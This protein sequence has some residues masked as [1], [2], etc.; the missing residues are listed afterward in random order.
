M[1][2]GERALQSM[3]VGDVID[4]S[5]EIYKRNFKQLTTLALIFYIPFI[6]I[7]SAVISYFSADVKNMT[8]GRGILN[9]DV[10][11]FTYMFMAYYLILLG[12]LFFYLIYSLT[13]KPIFDASVVNI[14]YS[15]VVHNKNCDLKAVIKESFKN[16]KKL[17][18]NRILYYLILFGIGIG[19]YIALIIV[20]FLLILGVASMNF[21]P[22]KSNFAVSVIVIPVLVIVSILMLVLAA[23]TISYFFAKYGM[24]IPFIV[25][26]NKSSSEAIVR[27]NDIST[28]SF[29]SISMSFALGILLFFTIPAIIS[30]STQGLVYVNKVLF[31]VASTA[32]QMIV[33]FLNPYVT[34]LL[35]VIFINQKIKTEGLDLEVK[36]DKMILEGAKAAGSVQEYGETADDSE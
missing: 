14:I 34:T 16:F 30:A 25:V 7:Y 32:A 4:Y 23:V 28:K 31:M 26:E 17:F 5:I 36:V 29:R 12:M 21:M 33:A 9:N 1:I 18:I 35:T 3:S 27:C 2:V 19:V 11:N 13:I 22:G 8:S 20:T 6:F 10:E 24:S 15:D